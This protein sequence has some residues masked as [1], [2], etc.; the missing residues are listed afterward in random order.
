MNEILLQ[1]KLFQPPL[2]ASL[3]RRPRLLALLDS[4]HSAALI[5]VSAPAGFGK[6]TLVVEWLNHVTA[7]TPAARMAWLSLDEEDNDPQRFLAYLG[8]ALQQSGTAWQPDGSLV[9]LLNAL[10][11]APP[12]FLVLDD[13]HVIRSTAIHNEL[14]FLLENAPPSLH[15][16]LM[17]RADPPLNL[18]L[19]R[20]RGQMIEIRARDLLFSAAE[21]AAFL[22]EAH[23]LALPDAD[24]QALTERTEGWITG[25]Q[26]AMLSLQRLPAAA[27]H[28]FVTN[29][30]GDD[31]YILD[32][33]LAEVLAHLGAERR[34]F[35]LQTAVLTD[36]S[37]SVCAAVTGLPTAGAEKMLVAL[38]RENL[39]LLPLDNR[40]EWYR[41]HQLFAD[42]LRSRLAATAPEQVAGIHQGAAAWYAAHNR[43]VAAI[44]HAIAGGDF[45][46]AAT[47]LQAP[48][49]LRYARPGQIL[50]WLAQLPEEA[51]D[52]RPQL[53]GKQLWVLLE[54]GQLDEVERRLAHLAGAA[55]SDPALAQ[56]LLVI[57]IHLARHRQDAPRTL[58]LARELLAQLPSPPTP[59]SRSAQLA[60]VF[61]LAEAYRL[62]GDAAAAQTQFREAARLSELAGSRAYELRARLGEAQVLVAQARWDEA[63]PVLLSVLAAADPDDKVEA[64]LARNLLAQ[65]PAAKS[66]YPALSAPLTDRE[67]DVLRYLASELTAAEIGQQL[68]ISTNTVKTH[69]KRIYA[70]LGARGRHEAVRLA[71]ERRLL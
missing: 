32:Y 2:R 34:A 66:A 38:A 29:F 16:V 61:G 46:Q 5:L 14:A 70:K 4:G 20:G 18:A 19:L 41:Y 39:F 71:R 51:L 52:G 11:G 37:A 22:N 50:D 35:L 48:D 30:A 3:V 17:T 25:L 31:R 13:Y 49:L 6:T 68:F 54:T 56:E 65:V 21:A 7:A 27:R 47:L 36:L 69:L 12:L 9:P 59:Q 42:L 40:G 44:H 10:V 15:L 55:K 8:A 33:L 60:A 1:T 58:S 23:A 53:A 64:A 43:P 57:R 67:L 24:L 45:V 26:L 63:L 28:A 62:A